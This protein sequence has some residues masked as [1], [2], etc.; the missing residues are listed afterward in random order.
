MRHRARS[1]C[2]GAGRGE[3]SGSARACAS[4]KV[5]WR[6]SRRSRSGRACQRRRGDPGARRARPPGDDAGARA[7]S[8]GAHRGRAG[9]D[10]AGRCAGAR[11]A[12]WPRPVCC[13]AV[14]RTRSWSSRRSWRRCRSTRVPSR[15]RPGAGACHAERRRQLAAELVESARAALADGAYALCLEILKQAAEIPPSDDVA[16]ESRRCAR[17]RK[18]H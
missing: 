2:S 3:R 9:E 6:S 11:A 4:S 12:A 15:P 14:R 1:R 10:R 8:R 5:S 18:R 16:M 7:R 13:R 17:R